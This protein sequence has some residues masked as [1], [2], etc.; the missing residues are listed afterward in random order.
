M[1]V[2]PPNVAA[3]R[4][5]KRGKVSRLATPTFVDNFSFAG[6]ILAMVTISHKTTQQRR[7]RAWPIV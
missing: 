4:T 2:T 3:N 1:A 7:I 5:K 6:D